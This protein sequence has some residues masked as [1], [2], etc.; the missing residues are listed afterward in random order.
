[1]PMMT[2]KQKMS[3]LVKEWFCISSDVQGLK[4][5]SQIVL[6]HACRGMLLTCTVDLPARAAVCN[7]KGFNGAHSCTTCLDSGDNTVGSTR[8]HRYWPFNPNCE[9]R[10]LDSVHRTVVRASQTG[11]TVS[12]SET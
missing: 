10:S 11:T 12:N 6:K 9:V 4:Y 1:M 7:M 5:P 2:H 8:M 3:V